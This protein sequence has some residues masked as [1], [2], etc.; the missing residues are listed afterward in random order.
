MAKSALIIGASG[1]V[2]GECLQALLADNYFD[3]VIALTRKP[4]NIQHKKL[5]NVIVD[6]NAPE[7]FRD[8]CKADLVFSV[9]GTTIAKAGS[10]EAFY[11]VDYT[12]PYTVAQVAQQLGAKQHILVSSVG[13][14]IESP[15]FYS[16]VKGGIE[17]AITDLHFETNIILRPSILLGHRNESRPMEKI[18]QAVAS[19][20]AFAFIGPL[21]SYK[22]ITA[23][24]V[25]K[26]MVLLAKSEINGTRVVENKELVN[27]EE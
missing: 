5:N 11:H 8:I 14:N 15:I 19:A 18:G 12:Y 22:G 4:L 17:K 7:T 25:A 9:M 20:L 27:F 2:G 10:K 1:L 21:A 13:A 26:A 16:K 23:K 3:Q 6:F 24:K